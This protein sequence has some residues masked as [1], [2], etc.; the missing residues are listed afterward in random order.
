[1]DASLARAKPPFPI[2]WATSTTEHWDDRL[3]FGFV[4]RAEATPIPSVG[5]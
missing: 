2:S 5:K 3:A 1:M 4:I